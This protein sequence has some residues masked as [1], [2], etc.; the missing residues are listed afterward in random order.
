M[1]HLLLGIALAACA[2]G[3]G[4]GP[5]T[6]TAGTSSHMICR[7]ETPTGTSISRTVCRTPEQMEDDRRNAEEL[8]RQQS[9]RPI[10]IP[11]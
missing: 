8:I 7:E 9:L 11:R 5:N 3:S 4:Q 1:R 10:R 6:T 2:P